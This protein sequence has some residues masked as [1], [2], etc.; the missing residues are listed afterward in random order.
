MGGDNGFLSVVGGKGVQRSATLK[1]RSCRS[2]RMTT[3]SP[4]SCASCWR[5]TASPSRDVTFERAGGLS[6]ASR[7]CS[8]ARTRHGPA[9][10]VRPA[11]AGERAMCSSRVPTSSSAP[12]R[13]WSAPRGAPGRAQNEPRWLASSARTARASISTIRRTARSPRRCSS[14]TAAA[15]TPQLARQSLGILL[16]ASRASY[17]DARLDTQG[18]HGA[19]AALEVRGPQAGRC[20]EIHGRVLPRT[21]RCC[22][23]CRLRQLSRGARGAHGDRGL[24][25][26]LRAR[27]RPAGLGSWR[28]R[29]TTTTRSTTT[30]SS[31]ARRT[32]SSR[33][34][35]S[36]TRAQDHSMHFNTNVLI[37]FQAKE[38][39][40]VETYV[41]VLQRF[42][43]RRVTARRATSTASRSETAPGA[44]RTAR[45]CS[46]TWCPSRCG[47][48][49]VFRRASPSRST[50]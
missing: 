48:R 42:A 3:G 47:S 41:L 26:A 12:T 19:R 39:A 5:R 38:R 18:R 29:S 37:E 46:A 45:W 20:R 43:D 2:T 16:D 44:S 30:A 49:R 10:A 22:I 13:A 33:T 1:A 32:R 21:G 11:R 17:R 40:F 4:S 15:M 7:S 35:R 6:S 8:T 36:C 50:A 14:P 34:S 25:E 23:E 28:A 24:P 27:G 31:R 9:H